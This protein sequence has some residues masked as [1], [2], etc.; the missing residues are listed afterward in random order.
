MP[1]RE[2]RA[3][4]VLRVVAPVGG[5]GTDDRSCPA[6]MAALRRVFVRSEVSRQGRIGSHGRIRKRKSRLP[7]DRIGPN[8]TRD[9]PGRR[10]PRPC[11]VVDRLRSYARASDAAKKWKNRK[12]YLRRKVARGTITAEER[13]RI[14]REEAPQAA[15]I[16][17]CHIKCQLA[18]LPHCRCACEGMMHGSAR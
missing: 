12:Q 15:H 3:L 11:L 10:S 7:P 4:Q 8:R 18:A 6:G 9:G 16:R 2:L 17:G 1:A 13:A 5:G 14:Q